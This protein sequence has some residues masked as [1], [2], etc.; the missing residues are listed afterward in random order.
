MS[1]QSQAELERQLKPA[2][3]ALA[4]LAVKLPEGTEKSA[5]RR[6]PAWRKLSARVAQIQG[7]I[8]AV[9]T[10]GT[11]TQDLARRKDEKAAAEAEANQPKAKAEKKK[12]PAAE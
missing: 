2:R 5:R 11:V 6:M 12:K 4:A 8:K 9:V 1:Q 7:R 3:S 10:Y